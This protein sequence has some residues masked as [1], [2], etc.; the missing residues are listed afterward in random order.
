MSNTT[1]QLKLLDYEFDEENQLVTWHVHDVSPDAPEDSK[2]MLCWKVSDLG[3]QFGIDT[4]L[5]P[6]AITSF[7]EAMKSRPMPFNMEVVVDR[8]PIQQNE[9]GKIDEED[10]KK[11]IDSIDLYPIQQIMLNQMKKGISMGKK[12][13]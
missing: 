12:D 7:C 2:V 3:M 13:D 9:E 8:L 5:S 4:Y 11:S 10:V 6:A 1:R